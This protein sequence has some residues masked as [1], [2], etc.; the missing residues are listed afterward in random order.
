MNGNSGRTHGR[1]WQVD[2]FAGKIFEGNPAGVCLLDGPADEDWMRAMAAEMNLSETAFVHRESSGKNEYFSIRYFTPLVEVPL[3]GHATLA[4]AHVLFEEGLGSAEDGLE[5]HA[6]GGE[7][8]AKRRTGGWIGIDYPSDIPE[9][10]PVPPGFSEAFGFDALTCHR[11]KAGLFAIVENE[12]LVRRANPDIRKMC[13]G[14]FGDMAISAASEGE[15]D[16][17]SRMFAPEMGID[18]DPVTGSIHLSLGQYWK[19]RLGRDALYAF[20]ASRRG[21]ALRLEIGPRRSIISGQARTVFSG[22]LAQSPL[23]R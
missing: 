4:T 21:G 19:T 20:Q 5:L 15:Y 23:S 3:C 9:E 12:E 16:F 22:I 18:E 13:S 1:I 2:A 10:F 6:P 14:G 11:S 17:V 8:L 7:F